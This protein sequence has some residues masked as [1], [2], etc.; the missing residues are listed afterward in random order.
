MA[1]RLNKSVLNEDP[2]APEISAPHW[3]GQAH[4]VRIDLRHPAIDPHGWEPHLW[5]RGGAGLD[6]P[7][8]HERRA[9]FR[10]Q[11]EDQTASAIERRIARELLEHERD[12]LRVE[13]GDI[14]RVKDA[15]AV[16]EDTGYLHPHD[17][18]TYFAELEVEKPDGR[19]L[20]APRFL[21]FIGATSLYN[22]P[23]IDFFDRLTERLRQDFGVASLEEIDLPLGVLPEDPRT[24]AV[25]LA[26]MVLVMARRSSINGGDHSSLIHAAAAA[27]Y[28]MGRFETQAAVEKAA[29]S[30]AAEGA[31]ASARRAKAAQEN[32][33]LLALAESIV[34]GENYRWGFSLHACTIRMMGVIH[35]DEAYKGFR[36]ADIS[37]L[38]RI[39]TPLFAQGADG[40]WH[41]I[42]P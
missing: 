16:V 37:R 8:L 15:W 3:H 32:A 38:R 20:A 17:H 30:R 9:K 41:P 4:G 2:E 36:S 22:A 19:R 6:W 11:A 40:V 31:A 1:E 39:A 34:R 7:W 14:V 21:R 25:A 28:A 33:P 26:A 18:T 35:S 24:R 27:G 5:A 23:L 12:F 10:A 42:K 13:A 29:K